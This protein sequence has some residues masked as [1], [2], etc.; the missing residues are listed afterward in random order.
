MFVLPPPSQTLVSGL[1]I[2]KDLRKLPDHLLIRMIVVLTA[3]YRELVPDLSKPRVWTSFKGYVAE[4]CQ[5][6]RISD[7]YIRLYESDE[8]L[9]RLCFQFSFVEEAKQWLIEF[10]EEKGYADIAVQNVATANP[11][12]LRDFFK[13][14][15][16]GPLYEM[17]QE[18]DAVGDWDQIEADANHYWQEVHP[19][20]PL[21]ERQ[22]A[23]KDAQ[24]SA[25]L[26]L[27]ILHNSV[28][29]M[30]YGESLT[31]LVQRTLAGGLD[32]DEAMC[33]AVRVDNGLRRH[34]EFA[35]RYLAASE[36]SDAD[37]MRK[38]NLT[39]SPLTNKIR[40]TG[41]YFLLSL[42]DCF[43][44]L[45][46]LTNAQLGDLCDHARLDKWENRIEDGG[47]L[48]RRRNEYLANKY[49]QLSRHSN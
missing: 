24:L 39:I 42:L 26:F 19:S 43:G 31:S 14:V 20:L 9:T 27:F 3:S 48:G 2:P 12:R 35:A 37:T 47:Y 6:L 29:V 23:E 22:R 1:S 4:R 46:R 34:P 25:G 38:Y 11:E 17:F 7:F 21:D 8:S 28:A 33:K 44:L 45:D 36:R 15:V 16:D 5:A 18:V 30:A 49:R 40:Y 32:A 41:L 10:A 13:A